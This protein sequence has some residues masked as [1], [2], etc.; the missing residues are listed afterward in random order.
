MVNGELW[1]AT[2]NRGIIECGSAV[3]VVGYSAGLVLVVAP[4]GDPEPLLEGES[5]G[6]DE[7]NKQPT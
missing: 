5:Q 3:Q 4:V 7:H 1:K 2:S 6:T